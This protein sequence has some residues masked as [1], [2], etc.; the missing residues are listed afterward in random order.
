MGKL[1]E[2]AEAYKAVEEMLYDGDQDTQIIQ[3]TLEA[4]MGEFEEKADNI[5]KMLRCMKADEEALKEEEAR[6]YTRRKSL[7]GRQDFLKGYLMENMRYIDKK[8]FKTALFSFS[9]QKNGGKEPLI[10][11]GSLDDIPGKY[12]VPQPPVLNNE[13]IRKLLAD[14]QV[15]WAHLEPRGEHLGIR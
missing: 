2:V 7:E 8:K 9:I 13:E 4:V 5:A 12:L 14:K 10:I 1:Y 15:D 6:L 3:D 11:D